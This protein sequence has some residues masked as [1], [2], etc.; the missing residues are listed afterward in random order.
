MFIWR[1]FTITFSSIF[2]MHTR[3]NTSYLLHSFIRQYLLFQ[4]NKARIRELVREPVRGAVSHVHPVRGG[5][6]EETPAEGGDGGG[7]S[8]VQVSSVLRIRDILVWIRIRNW[9][10]GS[11]PL[12][13]GSGSCYFR[14]WPSRCQQKT[15]LKKRFSAY[16]FLKVHLLNF[17]KIISQKEVTQESK[18][19]LL[20]LL[21][22]RRI[23]IRFQES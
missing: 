9:I 1:T 20:F 17:S 7:G 13:Y 22:D 23:R 15:N 16:Y 14:H 11:M 19:F 3:F 12:T 6:G 8:Q 10:R 5:Q 4:R 2:I 21:G 18:F